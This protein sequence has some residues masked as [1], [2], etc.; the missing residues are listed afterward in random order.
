[1][2][3]LNV[4]EMN[5]IIKEATQGL[6]PSLTTSAAL[7]MRRK[8]D[9]EVAEFKTQGIMPGLSRNKN[10]TR[11][12][13]MKSEKYDPTIQQIAA[14]VVSRFGYAG[15]VTDTK[16]HDDG[17]LTVTVQHRTLEG[18]ECTRWKSCAMH[19]AWRLS[20]TN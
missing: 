1:M 4:E 6:P 18:P 16:Q 8:M 20:A 14:R 19:P 11:G 9:I 10:A 2:N 5:Q 13:T 15:R 12:H 7:K 3:E 17:T